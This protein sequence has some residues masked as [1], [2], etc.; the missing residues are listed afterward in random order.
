MEMSVYSI[1]WSL[2]KVDCLNVDT[3]KLL[4]IAV[5]VTEGD[6]LATVDQWEASIAPRDLNPDQSQE[7]IVIHYDRSLDT[8]NEWWVKQHGTTRRALRRGAGRATQHSLPGGGSV[9]RCLHL[10]GCESSPI[11]RYVHVRSQLVR[12]RQLQSTAK[13]GSL[14]SGQAERSIVT[15]DL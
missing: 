3:D 7:S 10:V 13:E 11:N 2:L 12:Y 9:G 5:I 1:L 8:M 14:V 4:E 15:V 6:T